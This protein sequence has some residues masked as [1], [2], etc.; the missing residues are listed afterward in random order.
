M[1]VPIFVI[2]GLP[3][4]NEVEHLPELQS[5]LNAALN[6]IVPGLTALRKEHLFTI[7]HDNATIY[8]ALMK[9]EAEMKDWK[10]MAKDF[11]LTID[12]SGLN[13]KS[14]EARLNS[15]KRTFPT[16][17]Q[18]VHYNIARATFDVMEDLPNI[19]IYGF[20]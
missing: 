6:K 13:R 9:N 18:D 12:M 5:K 3:N 11:E 15:I 17:Y 8:A 20:L 19:K 1:R 2:A 4:K 7:R 14:L 10:K 16:L